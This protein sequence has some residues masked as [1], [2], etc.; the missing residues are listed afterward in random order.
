MIMDKVNKVSKV[1]EV[2]RGQRLYR[3]EDEAFNLAAENATMATSDYAATQ[4]SD[5]L[6]FH[7]GTN[8]IKLGK[9]H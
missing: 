7:R 5:L 1:L 2:N 3:I 4:E 6:C 9:R 8:S